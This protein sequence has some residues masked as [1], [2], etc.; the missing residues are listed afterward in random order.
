[1]GRK[2][3]ATAKNIVNSV[4]YLAGP[5][6]VTGE[7]LHVYGKRPRLMLVVASKRQEKGAA[8]WHRFPVSQGD[9]S[10]GTACCAAAK[11]LDY[12]IRCA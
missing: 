3:S 12:S 2:K 1:M 5:G 9:G 10:G 4:A 11:D 7:V 6:K 8:P